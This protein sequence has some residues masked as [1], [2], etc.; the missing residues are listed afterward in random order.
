MQSVSISYDDNHFT[1]GT[2]SGFKHKNRAYD[3]LNETKNEKVLNKLFQLEV[4]YFK[5][6]WCN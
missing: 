5:S 2:S 6:M 3:L 1:M 4:F